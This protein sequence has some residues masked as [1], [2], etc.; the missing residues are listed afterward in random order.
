MACFGLQHMVLVRRLVSLAFCVAVAAV[1]STL[2]GDVFFADGAQWPD[3]ARIA[4][5]ALS[6]AWLAWGASLALNGLTVSPPRE[7]RTGDVLPPSAT[8][9]V[10][11]PV[12]NEDPAKTFSHV[13]AMAHG[14]AEAGAGETF[15]FAVL[16]DTSNEQIAQSE[17]FWFARL[18]HELADRF[19]M[20]YRRR[21]DNAGRKAGNI[22][23][24][25]R[26][27]GARYD[28]L[29]VLDADSLLEPQTMFDMVRR[30][31][32]D[33]DL[34]LLQTLPRIVRARSLFGR[35]I[36]FS[37][38]FYAPFFARGLATLQGGEGPF[39]GHNAIVRTRA[40]AQSCALPALP[41]KPPLGGHILSHDFVEAALL[42]RN[43]WKVRVDPDL[44]GSYEEGPDNI[45]DYAK[46]DRRWC[47]GNL[48]HS[49]VLPA[50]GLKPWS[51]F[52]FVQGIM[53]YAASPVWALF[54]A[55]S[56]IAPTI[57]GPH[58]YFPVPG[59]QPVFP[60]AEQIQAL[61]LLTGVVGLLVGPKLLIVLRG[62]LSGENRPFGGSLRAATGMVIE[63][64]VSSLLAPVMLVYQTRAVLEVL[65]GADG[66]WPAADRQARAVSLGRAWAASWW[67]C[68]TGLITLG[69]AIELAPNYFQWILLIAVP[70]I[71]ASL[72]IAGTSSTV[73]GDLVAAFGLLATPQ[74]RQPTPVLARQEAVLA[75]WRTEPWPPDLAPPDGNPL[76]L[77]APAGLGRE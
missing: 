59:F 22:A 26:T 21:A 37:A 14:L 13:A 72:L 38:S 54:I 61:T 57:A 73:A 58:E 32:A 56:I 42:A 29:I 45:V 9:A 25:I 68:A 4:L 24:F 15:Q 43:G 35:A 55:A 18:R 30:M 70:Q 44:E 46:R 16:S 8:V 6:S 71:V 74:E 51:R 66:G 64:I 31:E 47:Q 10:L 12:Y 69:A 62:A 77:A 2:A 52:A 27:S 67:I 60:R 65:A 76:P 36:Q 53:A 34:G 75:A 23:D 7:R 17:E 1:A 19:A 20:F 11:V 48:Q 49:R 40:F 33:P 50:A 63:L 28:Y 39:W 3:Y 5:V 41:G